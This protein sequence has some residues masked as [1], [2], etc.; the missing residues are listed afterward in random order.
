[1]AVLV[2]GMVSA[3]FSSARRAEKANAIPF[4]ENFRKRID[5][6]TKSIAV[7]IQIPVGIKRR[8]RFLICSGADFLFQSF[9]KRHK[10]SPFDFLYYSL[11]Q[12]FPFFNARM[13]QLYAILLQIRSTYA[14]LW[15]GDDL[16]GRAF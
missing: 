5:C 6:F 14:I 11:H 4:A 13:F 12:N 8:K 3:D 15:A 7:K 9:C 2:V 10:T 16:I 1:M